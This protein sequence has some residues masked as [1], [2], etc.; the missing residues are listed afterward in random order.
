MH[1]HGM[2]KEKYKGLFDTFERRAF[3]QENVDFIL[4]D[5]IGTLRVRL[6]KEILE[7]RNIIVGF[8]KLRRE[9]KEERQRIEEEWEKVRKR[10]NEIK[11]DIRELKKELKEVERRE[12]ELRVVRDGYIR[13]N[14]KLKIAG[15][16]VKLASEVE[17]YRKE[18]QKKRE[19][20]VEYGRYVDKLRVDIEKCMEAN[21]RLEYQYKSEV[22]KS[23]ELAR[24]NNE[25]LMNSGG[26]GIPLE[27]ILKAIRNKRIGIV[28]GSSMHSTIRNFKEK[29][30]VLY[31]GFTKLNGTMNKLDLVV[32]VTGD[33]SHSVAYEVSSVA[34]KKG[35]EMYSFNGQNVGQLFKEVFNQVYK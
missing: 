11:Q 15:D 21:N 18:N 7:S 9:R 20:L 19:E 34:R 10:D 29:N 5:H 2:T 14:E 13:E 25:L 8:L 23:A 31:D 32:L 26:S 28:G 4:F 16:A 30:I 22:S 35:I 3:Y 1:V 33:L 17:K 24:V 12:E 27:N 6:Y